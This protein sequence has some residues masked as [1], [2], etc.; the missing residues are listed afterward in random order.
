MSATLDDVGVSHTHT[1]IGILLAPCAQQPIV[2]ARVR[3]VGTIGGLW[4]ASGGGMH[5]R[6]RGNR[7]QD[8]KQHDC[9]V[10]HR[11][12]LFPELDSISKF[13]EFG[14]ITE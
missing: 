3:D 10:R 12:S 8:R 9:N 1:L 13:F 14:G 6:A 7:I 11:F 4:A 2:C 5:F